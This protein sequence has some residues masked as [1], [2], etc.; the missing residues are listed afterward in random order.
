MRAVASSLP[1]LCNCMSFA[2]AEDRPQAS[3]RERE[4]ACECDSENNN[5]QQESI[6]NNGLI[7]IY[8]IVEA[9]QDTCSPILYTIKYP[10]RTTRYVLFICFINGIEASGEMT[11]TTTKT[12][13]GINCSH[14]FTHSTRI[15]GM[16]LQS[17]RHDEEIKSKSNKNTEKSI[18]DCIDESAE[19]LL[20]HE[21]RLSI[22]DFIEVLPLNRTP[23]F[24]I[25]GT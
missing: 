25:R 5:T 16:W 11:M 22:C 7:P 24:G 23:S 1:V 17:C 19:R 21:F 13:C 15:A 12:I 8:G 2:L 3:K 20:L 18:Y 9:R 4:G 14:S 6:Q 10:R